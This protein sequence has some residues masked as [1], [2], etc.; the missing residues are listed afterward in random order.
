MKANVLI[1]KWVTLGKT[2]CCRAFSFRYNTPGSWLRLTLTRPAAPRKL[3]RGRLW[4]VKV[5]AKY[6]MIWLVSCGTFRITPSGFIH[7]LK[8]LS[9]SSELDTV[10]GAQL[11]NNTG[12]VSGSSLHLLRK[13]GFSFNEE[14]FSSLTK[15]AL[16]SCFI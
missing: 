7:S 11:E 13:G 2:W 16:T 14:F 10:I 12:P 5:K 8:R 9:A 15:G 4:Q 1:Y 6:V 3:P